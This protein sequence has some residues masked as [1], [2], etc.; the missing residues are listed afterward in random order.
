MIG[1]LINLLIVLLV[2][3]VAWWVFTIVASMLGLP[4]P[5]LQIAK[6]IFVV[7]CLIIFLSLLSSIAGSSLGWHPFWR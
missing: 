1:L 5:I 2:L 4:P 3:G 6:V 7:I